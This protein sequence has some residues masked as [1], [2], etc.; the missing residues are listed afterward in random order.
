M[1][2]LFLL[3][4]CN[5]PSKFNNSFILLQNNTYLTVQLCENNMSNQQVNMPQNTHICIQLQP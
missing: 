1:I 5:I 2:I 4:S 3:F